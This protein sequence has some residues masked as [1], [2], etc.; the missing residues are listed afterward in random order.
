LVSQSGRGT[1]ASERDKSAAALFAQ[2][3]YQSIVMGATSM[4]DIIADAAAAMS[5]LPAMPKRDHFWTC[6]RNLLE[7]EPDDASHH[8]HNYG[9]NNHESI[10]V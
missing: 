6:S 10:V 5:D 4:A 1:V 3:K 2:P 8:H 7:H 9:K